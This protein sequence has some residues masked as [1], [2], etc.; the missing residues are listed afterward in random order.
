LVGS[1][2]VRRADALPGNAVVSAGAEAKWPRDFRSRR[3]RC[4]RLPAFEQ[5]AHPFPCRAGGADISLYPQAFIAPPWR[6]IFGFDAERK[7]TFQEA[8]ATYEV[9]RETYSGLGYDL[10]PLPLGSI[11]ECVRFVLAAIDRI[12]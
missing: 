6:E 12:M 7:Q 4:T 2:R 9:M 10:V 3:A 5:P 8:E 11:Q 1:A